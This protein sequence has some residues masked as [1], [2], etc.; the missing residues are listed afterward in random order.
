MNG[1]LG[2]SDT[3][4]LSAWLDGEAPA[5]RAAEVER[6]IRDDETW[7]QAH[8]EMLAV[9]AALDS[10]TVPAA[11]PDLAE[12][13]LAGVH[14]QAGRSKVLRIAAWLGPVA[15]AAAILLVAFL[16]LQGPDKPLAPDPRT[17]RTELERSEAFQGV[18]NVERAALEEETIRHLS[19]LR[20][21]DV[22]EEFETLE[23]IERLE[24]QGI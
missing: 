16:V 13:I 10:Y 3:D 11:S 8:R 21:Y 22:A 6:L 20:D 24:S 4:D 1:K 19:F 2:Q 23:A 9:D 5:D 7:R 17:A 18:P 14:R 12:R 15:A